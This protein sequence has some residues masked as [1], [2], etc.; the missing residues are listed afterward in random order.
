MIY[1]SKTG[2]AMYYH[3]I[4]EI[5]LMKNIKPN[6]LIIVDCY[7]ILNQSFFSGNNI[8]NL[9]IDQNKQ[10]NILQQNNISDRDI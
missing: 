8:L 1:F 9:Q 5:C 7:R 10:Q 3:E 6:P 4:I 2:L